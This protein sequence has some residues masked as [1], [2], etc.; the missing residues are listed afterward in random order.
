MRCSAR[1]RAACPMVQSKEGRARRV[2]PRLKVAY[3]GKVARV[4]FDGDSEAAGLAGFMRAMATTD[5]DFAAGLI[6]QFCTIGTVGGKIDEEALNFVAAIVKGVAP[7]D[8]V[9]AMLAV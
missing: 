4:S 8:Q 6:K 3:R 2:P 5:T 9:E 7:K 1:V